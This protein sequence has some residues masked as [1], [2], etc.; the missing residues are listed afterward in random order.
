MDHLHFR[1]ELHAIEAVVAGQ[2]NLS[3]IDNSRNE[4]GFA[5]FRREGAGPW[6]QIAL[7]GPNI[8]RFADLEIE[9]GKTYTYRVHAVSSSGVSEWSNEATITVPL[10]PQPPAAPDSK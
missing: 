9:V 6:Q 7:L 5:V 2:V 8:T 4:T 3:W 10:P 1:E